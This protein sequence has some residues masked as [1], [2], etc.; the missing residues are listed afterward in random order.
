[1]LG[2]L[3]EQLHG[4][5]WRE[6]LKRE[7][8]DPLSMTRTTPMPQDPHAGGWAVHPWADLMLPEPAE[9]AGAMAPA[10]QLWS[11]AEDLCRFAAFLESGNDQVLRADT[12][13]E[14]RRP[15][16]V[17]DEWWTAGYG[18]GMQI[19]RSDK[20]TLVGHTGSM[21][22]FLATVWVSVEEHLAAVVLANATSGPPIGAVAADLVRIVADN[23]PP[24]PQ[25][26]R[27][28]AEVDDD[29]LAL[30]GPWYWGA[31][32]FA[33]YLRD[34]RALELKP[35]A[36]GGRA[37]KFRAEADGTWTGLD[38][39]Y[40]GE[41]LRVV[42][43]TDGAVSHLDLGTFILTRGPYDPAGPVPGGVDPQGW[44]A[45]PR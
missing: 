21:P 5:P 41:T 4:E 3:V 45:F 22:G 42:R 17:G 12:L 30:T 13:A 20:R 9:D 8:L 7:V 33:L 29:L 39:Y 19:L 44:R 16:G 31:H 18:L 28:L 37:S 10:G 34:D 26:W 6:V 43:G 32:P 24:I 25:P 11:T 2:K 36:G 40:T 35:L 14:M 38:G 1:V 15:A 23:E 27:P